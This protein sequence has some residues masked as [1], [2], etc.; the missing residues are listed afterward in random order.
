VHQ[1]CSCWSRFRL[2][3]Q[4]KVEDESFIEGKDRHRDLFVMTSL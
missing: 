2:R 4:L 1:L 3:V